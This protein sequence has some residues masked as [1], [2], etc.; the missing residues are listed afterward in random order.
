MTDTPPGYAPLR[1]GEGKLIQRFNFVI[2]IYFFIRC[3]HHRHGL[4]QGTSHGI[5]Q[6][7]LPSSEAAPTSGEATLRRGRSCLWT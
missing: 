1:L 3:F 2:D 7:G 6:Q 4:E 5:G